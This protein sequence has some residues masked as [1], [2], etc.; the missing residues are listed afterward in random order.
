MT[1][2]ESMNIFDTAPSYEDWCE[3]NGL[4]SEDDENYISY[5][6]WKANS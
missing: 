4:D 6:E 1:V 2:A 3:A 5:S